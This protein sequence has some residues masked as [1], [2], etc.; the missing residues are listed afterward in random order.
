MSDCGFHCSLKGARALL[1]QRFSVSANLLRNFLK[2]HILDPCRRCR[3]RRRVL[4]FSRCNNPHPTATE[5]CRQ[6]QQPTG[7]GKA[8]M[9]AEPRCLICTE[10][11]S[12]E[13]IL[14]KA[15][16]RCAQLFCSSC[17][18]TMYRNAISSQSSMPPRCCVFIPLHF[19]LE[20]LTDQEA[21]DFRAAFEEFSTP[22]V[23]RLYCPNRT[24]SKF[25]PV[26]LLRSC[27]DAT[28]SKSETI[29]RCPACDAEACTLCKGFAHPS[30]PCPPQEIDDTLNSQLRKWGYKRCPHCGN[31]VR[32]M[33]GCSH[34]EC[35]CGAH[36]CWG[37]LQ[38]WEGDCDCGSEDMDEEDIDGETEEGDGDN[39]GE[40]GDDDNANGERPNQQQQHH[41]QVQE[42]TRR[43][44]QRQRS[45]NLDAHPHHYW[46]CAG[47]NFGDEPTDDFRASLVCRCKHSWVDPILGALED[48]S[49]DIQIECHRCWSVAN[50][51]VRCVECQYC[52]MV[53]CRKCSEKC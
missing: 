33:Y 41:G 49:E 29:I 53:V 4:A 21:G 16:R 27:K 26:R 6:A 50:K 43:P 15:C 42:E 28:N 36:W 31:G 39:D 34:M 48:E 47:V 11:A 51:K 37:C 10:S 19:A 24:C 14:I 5:G 38:P 18:T 40:D 35:I 30:T 32:K 44:L 45:R 20:D 9:E 23:Q 25:I 8:Q 22:G 3:R 13:R 12:K 7:T 46:E 1:K 2:Q 52:G 17:I